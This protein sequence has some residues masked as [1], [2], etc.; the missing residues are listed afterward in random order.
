MVKK[1]YRTCFEGSLIDALHDLDA[2]MVA[3]FYCFILLFFCA[4]IVQK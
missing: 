3:M 1:K 2:L 4:V